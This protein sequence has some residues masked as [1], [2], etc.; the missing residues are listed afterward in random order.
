MNRLAKLT[1]NS[2]STMDVYFFILFLS[3]SVEILSTF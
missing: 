2:K 3:L 1:E